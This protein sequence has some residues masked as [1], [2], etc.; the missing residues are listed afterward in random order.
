[1][2]DVNAVE[3]NQGRK[4]SPVSFSD[5]FS[6]QIRLFCKAL[7]EPIQRFKQRS[8]CLF[9]RFL[10]AGKAGPVNAIIDRVVDAG[11]DVI[12]LLAQCFRV[13]VA[14]RRCRQCVKGGVEH[15]DD[16]GAFIGDDGVFLAVPE[17]GH[18]DAA[19]IVR[20]CGGIDLVHAGFAVDAIGQCVGKIA[21]D[22]PAFRQ[23]E[24]IDNGE[25][26]FVFEIFQVSYNERAMRPWAGKRD[27]EVIATGLALETV[28]ACGACGTVG[29]DP[30]AE[31]GILPHEATACAFGVVPFV[32]PLAF[33]EL[34]HDA[35]CSLE[36]W[37]RLAE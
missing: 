30:V 7:F 28:C 27:I 36:K 29:G 11:I 14:H 25:R 6:H 31:A 17:D 10:R 37:N 15:A 3:A 24:R 35:S 2:P 22:G 34:S 16:V 13:V 19:C 20:L 1:M 4:Q 23:H 8:Y 32:V 12:N 33:D 5:L 9:V 21:F 26:D 18:G